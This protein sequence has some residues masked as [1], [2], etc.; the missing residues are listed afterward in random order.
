MSYSEPLS[1]QIRVF[2][3]SVGV[4]VFICLLYIAVQSLFALFGKSNRVYYFAD[5]VFSVLFAFV[6]FFFMVLYN[7][8]RVRLHLILGEAL[9]FFVFYF[10]VGK[11]LHSALERLTVLIR[12]T[13]GIILL[14]VRSVLRHFIIGMREIRDSLVRL[15]D[16]KPDGEK[17]EEKKAKKFKILGKIHLKNRNKSV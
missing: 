14:P 12:K 1:N 17:T 3:L 15:K 9:G 13:V 4:G 8:G 2:F 6:S 7:S 5:G 16:K 11:Y 10:S